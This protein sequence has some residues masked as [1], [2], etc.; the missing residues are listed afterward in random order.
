MAESNEMCVVCGKELAER[1]YDPA[2]LA[3]YGRCC[4]ECNARKVLPARKEQQGE[5]RLES[6]HESD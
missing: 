5:G 1:H 2:P 4:D 3:D 6:E